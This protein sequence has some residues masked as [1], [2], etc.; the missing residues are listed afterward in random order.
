MAILLVG[1]F[2]LPAIA[3]YTK[4]RAARKKI[5][6]AIN[7]HYLMMEID[8]A[9]AI[10]KGTINACGDKCS[11]Q[12][13]ANAW[14]YVG[15]VR[16]SGRNDQAGATEAFLQARTL[17][18]NVTLDAAMATPETQA[19]FA[20][21]GGSVQ[22]A[23][24]VPV[25]GGGD[26]EAIPG[27]MLC[28]PE[29]RE[30]ETRRA[31]PVS[32]QTEE[33]GKRAELKFKAPGGEWS[34]VAMKKVG[35]SW[36]AEIPCTETNNAGTLHWY[37]QVWDNI[38][39]VIDSLGSRRQPVEMRLLESS[40]EAPPAF[41]GKSAP[42]R[43]TSASDCPPDFPG[44]ADDN[45]C[46]DKDWG[47]SCDNSSECKCGLL[48]VDG[49]CETAPS[50]DVDDDC[51]SGICVDGT[52]SAGGEVP[53]GPKKHWIGVHGAMD[54]LLMGTFENACRPD[55]QDE[56][57]LG[58]YALGDKYPLYNDEAPTVPPGTAGGFAPA[59]I[60]LLLSYD[61][62]FH[63]KMSVGL[64]AGYA[65]LGSPMDF[66]PIHAEARFGYWFLGNDQPGL[67]PYV[68]VG[69]GYAQVDGLV[70]R[71]G[72]ESCRP[73]GCEN[74]DIN[75]YQRTGPFFGMLG[76]GA[77]YAFSRSLGVQLNLNAMIM[78]P[79]LGTVVQPSLGL[80]YGL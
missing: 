64:R 56:F 11:P 80:V 2:S 67:R 33:D 66:V 49:A 52:C 34:K 13:L 3:Q 53:R 35:D 50:C 48:C 32:C 62:A 78:Q 4:D 41:P 20:E 29:V 45:K 44:C 58:C 15:I 69:G 59:Q 22:A 23:P 76:G 54:F 46:G 60:R 16:G 47:V 38:D 72:V 63:P 61:F 7:Q 43:C 6:E 68:H 17:D 9:E 30:V 1:L 73:Q 19:S 21:A 26:D 70:V 65:L 37:V 71:P 42:A 27:D 36:Q 12:T 28:T 5:D 31:I 10:L 75:I 57:N 77:V 74:L 24:A 79:S 18:P 8:K 14:M 25:A 40:S 39:E 55:V 51:P